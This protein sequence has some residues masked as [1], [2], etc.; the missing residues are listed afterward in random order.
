MLDSVALHGLTRWLG[1][2]ARRIAEAIHHRP[3]R[4]ELLTKIE[5]VIPEGRISALVTILDISGL[6]ENDAR[7]FVAARTAWEKIERHIWALEREAEMKKLQAWQR[8]R[9]NV[10]LASGAG[11]I[12]A[13]LGTLFLDSAK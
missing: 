4:G 12:L 7:G 13:F 1:G 8:G 11:S 6:T 10:P 3:T 9:D 2:F 5:E